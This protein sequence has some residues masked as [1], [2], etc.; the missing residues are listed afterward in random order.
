MQA[1]R[2]EALAGAAQVGRAALERITASRDQIT[3]ALRRLEAIRAR[4]L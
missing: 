1:S 3:A 4:L 2:L